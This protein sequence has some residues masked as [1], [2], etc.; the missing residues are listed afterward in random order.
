MT[1]NEEVWVRKVTGRIKEKRLTK[2]TLKDTMECL[3]KAVKTVERN[4][5]VLKKRLFHLQLIYRAGCL[6]N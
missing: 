3:I 6:N 1:E 5:V 2:K 4:V